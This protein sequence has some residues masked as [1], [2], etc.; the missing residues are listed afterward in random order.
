[1]STQPERAADYECHQCGR[2]FTSVNPYDCM[3]PGG[4]VY[5]PFCTRKCLDYWAARFE[6]SRCG[7]E[8]PDGN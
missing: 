5:G 8:A 4:K 3:V 7:A 2:R 6:G 1:M